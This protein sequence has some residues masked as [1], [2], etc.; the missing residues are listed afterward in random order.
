MDGVPAQV[1]RRGY[2]VSL[3]EV[4]KSHLDRVLGNLLWGALPEQRAW[5]RWPTGAHANLKLILQ[6]HR[7]VKKI[8]YSQEFCFF[9]KI[10]S[11]INNRKHSMKMKI[12]SFAM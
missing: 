11:K 9:T 2:G 6:N 1:A 12:S 3:L 4:T 7:M 10:S 8:L 5:T